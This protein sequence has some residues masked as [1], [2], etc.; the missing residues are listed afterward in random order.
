MAI[1]VYYSKKQKE[2]KMKTTLPLP[3]IEK[4]IPVSKEVVQNLGYPFCYV[5]LF[6]NETFGQTDVDYIKNKIKANNL[7]SIV[8]KNQSFTFRSMLTLVQFYNSFINDTKCPANVK[9]FLDAYV[10][11]LYRGI[12]SI[13]TENYVIPTNFMI[14]RWMETCR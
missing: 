9:K 10:G 11:A 1:A 5:D 13:K 6:C 2:Y 14:D 4:Q 8:H 12:Q 7:Y 3:N